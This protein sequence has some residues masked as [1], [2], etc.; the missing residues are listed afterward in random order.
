MT[1]YLGNGAPWS[2]ERNVERHR[3]CLA[4]WAEHRFGWHAIITSDDGAFRGIAALSRLGDLVPGIEPAAV[5]VGWWVDPELWGRGI[6]KEAATALREEAFA[7][8]RAERLV[9]RYQPANIASGRVMAGL[10]MRVWGDIVGQAGEPVRVY[11]MDRAE[12]EA[13]FG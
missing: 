1:R 4:H 8:V 6:A 11:V 9:A 10:G 2:R 12:W 5:E 7:E 13:E 3:A